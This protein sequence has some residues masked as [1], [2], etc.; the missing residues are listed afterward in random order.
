MPTHASQPSQYARQFAV[1]VVA[2]DYHYAA[3]LPGLDP[4]VVPFTGQE[5]QKVC[6]IRVFGSTLSGQKTCLHVHQVWSYVYFH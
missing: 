5:V 6:V 1:R 4:M 3:P 2:L